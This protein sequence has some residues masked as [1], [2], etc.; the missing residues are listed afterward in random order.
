MKKIDGINV[1]VEGFAPDDHPTNEELKA[2][3]DYAKERVENLTSITVVLCADGM[4]DLKYKAQGER[5]ERI[6]RITGEPD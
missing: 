3:V 4:V 1:S 5:F 2:Y 6:R